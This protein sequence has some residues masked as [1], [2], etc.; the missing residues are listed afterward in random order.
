MWLVCTSWDAKLFLAI[1]VL[2][3]VCIHITCLDSWIMHYSFF[4]QRPYIL[5]TQWVSRVLKY[6][7]KCLED[8]TTFFK[9][10]WWGDSKNMEE[11]ELSRW[12]IEGRLRQGKNVLPYGLNW[13]C[14]F[15]GSSK[16]HRENFISFIF[17]ESPHQ[18]GMKNLVKSSKRFFGYFNT[19]ETHSV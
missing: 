17:L 6:P 5:C 19:L 7:K 3:I 16:S 15:T 14:Y 9:S 18:V 11:I 4:L 10:T 2:I 12:L 13:L 8:L 1:F